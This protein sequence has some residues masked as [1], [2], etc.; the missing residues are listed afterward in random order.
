MAY[1]SYFPVTYQPYQMFQQP[2]Q[3]QMQQPAQQARTVE[4]MAVPNE[5]AVSDFIVPVGI[6]QEFVAIDDS[7]VAFKSNSAN[8]QVNITFY[9]K[10]PPAP[11]EPPF[12]PGDYVRRDEIDALISQAM[13]SQTHKRAAKK[14][15]EEE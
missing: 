14:E 13:A 15:D 11:I 2:I 4:V 7:F 5:Q 3:S 10:R 8:G 6:T 12:N 9:D 1:N